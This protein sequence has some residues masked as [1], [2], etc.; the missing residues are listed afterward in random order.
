MPPRSDRSRVSRYGETGPLAAFIEISTAKHQWPLIL[1]FRLKRRLETKQPVRT[2]NG[3]S[4]TPS[5]ISRGD[6]RHL[7]KFLAFGMLSVCAARATY[8]RGSAAGCL[9]VFSTPGSLSFVQ[10][11]LAH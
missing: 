7:N 9:A 4:V 8:Q 2:S 6:V 3:H 1:A 10:S 5:L 11:R